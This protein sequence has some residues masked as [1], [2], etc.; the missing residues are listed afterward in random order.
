MGSRPQSSWLLGLRS[1]GTLPSILTGSPI[2]SG[3][4]FTSKSLFFFRARIF[5]GPSFGGFSPVTRLLPLVT[6]FVSPLV[7][8]YD[9]ASGI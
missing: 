7:E 3:S 5:S 4:A 6:H 2:N 8:N 1:I 9:T